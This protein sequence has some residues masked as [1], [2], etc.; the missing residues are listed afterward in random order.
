MAA[1]ELDPIKRFDKSAL[2]Y[3]VAFEEAANQLADIAEEIIQ[4]RIASNTTHSDDLLG[5]LLQM[6]EHI[7]M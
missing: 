7:S 2:S 1:S 5:I 4:T 3:F 6:R